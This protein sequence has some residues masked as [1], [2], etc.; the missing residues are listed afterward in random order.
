MSVSIFQ[1]D[2]QW[3]LVFINERRLARLRAFL[4]WHW[5]W[6]ECCSLFIIR[7]FHS[8]TVSAALGLYVQTKALTILVLFAIHVEI[9][10]LFL[11]YTKFLCDTF[12]G[13]WTSCSF[14]NTLYLSVVGTCLPRSYNYHTTFYLKTQLKP[15]RFKKILVL[16]SEKNKQSIFVSKLGK[17][18]V[19]TETQ[20]S[21]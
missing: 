11:V 9:V 12:L 5:D 2:H 20:L 18:G 15:N 6:L 10:F 17:Y 19:V 7:Y 8:S 16:N 3:P 13:P 21:L 14:F 4:W 1:T